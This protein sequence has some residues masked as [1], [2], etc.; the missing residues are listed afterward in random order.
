MST[1]ASEI[2]LIL[3]QVQG[4]KFPE[5]IFG[6][7]E[8]KK[9]YLRLQKLT[10]PDKHSASDDTIRGMAEEASKLL[11]VLWTAAQQALNEGTYGERK[12]EPHATTDVGFTSKF[13]Q[14]KL[15]E[16]F[17][18]G[19]TCAVFN[20]SMWDSHLNHAAAVIR[21]PHSKQ[22]NDLMQR[23]V[24]AFQ[25]LREKERNLLDMDDGT[26]QTTRLFAQRLPVFIE[27]I[28]LKEPNNPKESKVVNAFA[29]MPDQPAGWHNL[30][31]VRNKYP[32]GVDGKHAAWMWRRVIE[33]MT[34]AHAAGVK[35][36]AI[37]P[38]HVIVHP[39]SHLAQV[40]DWTS[41][42]I[43]SDTTIPYRDK[44]WAEWYPPEGIATVKGDIYTTACTILYVLGGEPNE[45][46]IP[47]AV[48]DPLRA[49]LNRCL[50]PKAKHRPASMVKLYDELHGA[51]HEAYGPRKFIQFDM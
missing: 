44:L 11:N 41:S 32:E 16:R 28:R 40:V 23:E 1:V 51:A 25:T 38:Q 12:V 13:H 33:G 26:A 35:H 14:Y 15:T 29:R 37:T 27:S 42:C 6:L 47:E 43:G 50:Q 19:S 8:P 20:G 3:E 7:D 18:T 4:A 24:K 39:D 46:V 5:D 22:D 34:F 48:P 49:L 9:V 45:M 30:E 10:H 17:Y 36:G 2:E 31:E 21:V